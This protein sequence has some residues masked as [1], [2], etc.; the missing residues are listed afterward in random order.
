MKTYLQLLNEVGKRLRR[1]NGSTYTT[2]TQDQNAVFI[3]SMINE[4]KRLVE[5]RWKWHQLRA[6]VEF[7][8]VANTAEYDLSGGQFVTNG[9][10]TNDR[11]F[12]LQD[13]GGQ[14]QFW[15]ITTAQSG[16]PMTRCTREYYDTIR[17]TGPTG[18]Q[19]PNVVTSWQNGSGLTIAFPFAPTGVRNYRVQV[20]NPQAELERASDQLL[21]PW[22]PVVLAAVALCCEE[23]G[24]E[25]GMPATRW[26]EEYENALKAQT[27]TDMV[28]EDL[29]LIPD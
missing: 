6:S 8:S 18:V 17:A 5:D 9:V 19:I 13:A 3:G 26:W 25:L 7:S 28:E 23:R 21:A 15:D 24:E 22:R 11:S 10:F 1:S 14:W 27:G 4:A 20:Y 12:I 2:L 29:T 16:T